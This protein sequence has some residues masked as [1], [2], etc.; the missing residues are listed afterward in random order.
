MARLVLG[1]DGLVLRE[2][3]LIK[4]RTTIG[5]RASSD[6]QIDNLVVS[7][8]HAVVVTILSDS[9]LEDLGSTNGTLVN[10]NPV[11][12]HFL[13]NNDVIELGK[14]K[15][16]YVSDQAEGAELPASIA[17]TQIVGRAAVGS[18]RADA[19]FESGLVSG[20]SPAY[21]GGAT[22]AAGLVD[23]DRNLVTPVMPA[24]PAPASSGGAARIPFTALASMTS[25]A[26][27]PLQ[28]LSAS[29]AASEPGRSPS[30]AP[31][32]PLPLSDAQRAA[33]LQ[34]LTGTHAG[35]GIDLV[36]PLNTIGRPGEQ[37][38]VITRRA[39]GY[40][41]THVEGETLPAINGREVHAGAVQLHDHDV[42]EL[43]GVKLE[44]YYKD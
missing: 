26:S 6:I 23:T 7:G 38:A 31:L 19:A 27:S 30:E 5:R 41:I 39:N 43:G 10:G 18:V 16:R 32:V 40:F 20:S 21:G 29:P 13:R 36:K 1:V 33:A 4:E 34:V 8:D 14:Y 24:V 42:V 37:V 44:F 17:K 11:R 2:I 9:F 3:P 12:K 25:F 22:P 15:L 35:R 28:A